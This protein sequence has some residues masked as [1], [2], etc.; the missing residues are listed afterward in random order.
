MKFERKHYYKLCSTIT[1]LP[2]FR[3][4]HTDSRH[5]LHYD[6]GKTTWT[7]PGT[8][9]LFIFAT[10]DEAEMFSSMQEKRDS[11]GITLFKCRVLGPVLPVRFIFISPPN[12]WGNMWDLDKKMTRQKRI[13]YTK[14][15]VMKVAFG[16][17]PTRTPVPWD[18]PAGTCSVQAVQLIK[19]V[20]QT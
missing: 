19:E 3:S 16:P 14:K 5:T 12:N 1:T 6:I 15:E 18:A 11:T 2:G 8:L 7:I 20:K 4:F 17:R 13:E 10:Y 9:G